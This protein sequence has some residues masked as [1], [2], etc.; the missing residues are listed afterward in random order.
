MTYRREAEENFFMAFIMVC[1][2]DPGNVN[3]WNPCPF[4]DCF[5]IPHEEE[6]YK[7]YRM[8]ERCRTFSVMC[9]FR[10]RVIVKG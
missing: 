10:V 3:I 9:K 4:G 2:C 7:S 5:S 8:Q 6:T 1:V